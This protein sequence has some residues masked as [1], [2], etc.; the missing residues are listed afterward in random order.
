MSSGASTSAGVA[1]QPMG[2]FFFGW[3]L[4]YKTIESA[5]NKQS[6]VLIALG[7]FVLIKYCKFECIGLGE[8]KTVSDDEVGSELLP[9][10]WNDEDSKYAL[11]YRYN[12]NLYLLLGH[13]AEDCLIMNLLDV[14]TKKVS[15]IGLEP[16]ELV[17]NKKGSLREILP[18]ASEIVDRYRKELIDPVF[19]GTTQEVTTQTTTALRRS[20]SG[21]DPLRIGP[22]MRPVGSFMPAG[23]DPRPF[24]FPDVG[25][26]DLDPLGRG[27]SGNLFEFPPHRP[28]LYGNAQPRFDP[29]G[30]PDPNVR[31]NPNPDHLQPP[32]FGGHNYYM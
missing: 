13:R 14:K 18:N 28:P 21:E 30:P 5:V 26:G 22:P 25:R 12:G 2:E 23:M 1:S 7:H 4:L 20:E 19:S 3:D 11:R 31:P 24:G 6:D 8:D 17:K 15:N 16:N 9:D 27:G 29:F 10:G 32:N